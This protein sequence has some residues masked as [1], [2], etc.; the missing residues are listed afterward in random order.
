[1]LLLTFVAVADAAAAVVAIVIVAVVVVVVAVVFCVHVVVVVVDL[2]AV[3]LMLSS[4]GPAALCASSFIQTFTKIYI[5]FFI[6]LNLCKKPKTY[7]HKNG[8]ER[9]I[10][11]FLFCFFF[12]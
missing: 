7:S 12:V 2:P 1:V 3:T 8:K 5:F 6:F 11:Y 9:N 10:K 4:T